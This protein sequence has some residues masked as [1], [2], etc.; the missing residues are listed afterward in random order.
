[1]AENLNSPEL[2]NS[3][4][5]LLVWK[6]DNGDMG[7]RELTSIPTSKLINDGNGTSSFATNDNVIHTTGNETKAGVLTLE[8]ELYIGEVGGARSIYFKRA[9]DG[10]PTASVGFPVTNS[11]FEFRF[12]LG[13][14]GSYGTFTQNGTERMRIAPETGNLL[15]GTSTDNTTDKLQITG[16]L[17]STG[18]IY[19]PS[20]SNLRNKQWNIF[21]DSFS[22]DISNDYVGRVRDLLGL[23]A[24]T[25]AVSGHRLSQ[26]LAIAKGFVASQPTY[27]QTFDIVSLH[28]GVNDFANDT[29][30][31]GTPTS[32]IGDGTFAGDLKDFIEVITTSNPKIKLYIITPPEANGS[33]VLYK[34]VNSEG[35]SLKDLSILISNVCLD[36]SVQCID[37]YSMSGLNLQT[38][39]S[40]TADGLHPNTDGMIRM[41]AIVAQAFQGNNSHGRT[42]NYEDIIHTT[43]DESKVGNLGLNGIFQMSRRTSG[44]VGVPSFDDLITYGTQAKI[45]GFNE[46]TNNFGKGWS[47]WTTPTGSN[48]GHEAFRLGYDK[49]ATF[50]GNVVHN[51]VPTTSAGAYDI[52]TRN[53]S[54]G[55]IEKVVSSTFALDNNVVHKS[56][57]ET[58]I[59]GDKTWTGSQVWDTTGFNIFRRTMAA[60]SG[61]AG[62][63]T[64]NAVSTGSPVDGFGGRFPLQIQNGT[65]AGLAWVRDGSDTSGKLIFQT[66]NAGVLGEYFTLD[67]AGKA[68]FSGTIEV[69]TPTT[70]V[71]AA[72][73]GYVD[74]LTVVNSTTT[75]LSSSDL[76]TTYP[77]VPIGTRVICK[78]IIAGALIYTKVT[79]AGS[80]DV[81]ISTP[82]TIVT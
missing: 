64:F 63:V 74:G 11:S 53:T 36:Y 28:I 80:S 47:F 57:T 25:N 16:I 9:S 79:E 69:P 49:T 60:T 27:F 18:N 26:Q 24:T 76:N 5:R 68:V 56:G 73:K 59:A 21:G 15:I 20:F 6:E 38:I 45:V 66:Y 55:I 50:Y 43:G 35:W 33:G 52:L 7:Y 8:D 72:N 4:E 54:T 70:S 82:A 81:W 77:T 22:N 32:T 14:G 3:S 12:N 31:L 42:G 1:M 61:I 40:L 71:Q 44:T 30:P 17:S 34:A 10:N 67:K 46:A 51:T 19:A 2:D 62:A 65:I 39:S 78:D 75:V 29:I 13:G 37:L 41:A 58:G 23:I 48:V